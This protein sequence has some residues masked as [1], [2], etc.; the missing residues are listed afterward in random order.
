MNSLARGIIFV[1]NRHIPPQTRPD[2]LLILRP[3][4]LVLGIGCNRST[5]SDEIE[6]CVNTH[7]RHILL[8]PKSV[9]CI[10]TAD[11][12]K[13]E[14]GLVAYAALLGVPLKFYT[15]D[16]LNRIEAPS[17]SSPH[18]LAAIGAHGVAEPAAMLASGGG[19]LLLKKIK[20]A[21]V[22]LAVAELCEGHHV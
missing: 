17:P 4:N 8:S 22:T 14:P 7:L 5:P 10:A 1:T 20:S 19:R 18:A 3:R 15:S 11:A 13:D 21:N 6:A 9:C 12:K 2:N 16:E